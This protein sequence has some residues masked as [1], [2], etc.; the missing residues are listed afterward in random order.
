MAN[1]PSTKKELTEMQETF[2]DQLLSNGGNVTEAMELAG[3]KPSSR[4]WLVKSVKDE[5]VSRTEHLLALSAAK[6]AQR[7][8]NTI[9]DD[10]SEPRSEIRLKAAESLL[11]RVGL[12]KKD[13]VQHNV[14]AVHGVVLL[15]S[16]K[17]AEEIIIESDD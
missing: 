11:N 17:Q 13:T 7:L 16:K 14:T 10:G 1:L 4:Q 9:D 8:I 5:I 3:Y 15:P 2:V 6:A 12:G